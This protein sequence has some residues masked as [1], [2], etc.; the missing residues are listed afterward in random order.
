MPILFRVKNIAAGI[1]TCFATLVCSAQ[2]LKV[3]IVKNETGYSLLRDNKPYFIKGAGGTSYIER[4]AA[5]GGNSVR[6]WGSNKGNEVLDKASKLGL[7]V[8]MGLDMTAERHGF[9]YDDTAA[10]RAQFE[11]LRR[12]VIKY[13]NHPALLMWGIGNELNLEYRNTNV[14]KAVNDGKND[15]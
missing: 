5:Y 9:N 1:I 10:V 2:P 3:T 11:R 8:T 4:L 7:T 13:R 6:T 12:E 14:W 15:P